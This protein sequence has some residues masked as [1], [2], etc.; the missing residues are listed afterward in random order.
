M[1]RLSQSLLI[2][3]FV[4]FSWLAMQAVH[5]SGHVMG[6]WATG[7][8][9]DKV[10]LRPLI[11]SSTEL[12]HNPHPL[13]VV[14]AGPFIGCLLPLAAFVLAKV[15]SCPGLYLFRFFA[16]FCLV[17]NG[18]YIAAGSFLG[19][20]DPGDMMRNGSPRWLLI[21]FGLVTIPAGLSMWHR[22]GIYFGLAGGHG[23]V[24]PV[25]TITSIALLVLLIA[26]ELTYGGR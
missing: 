23:K 22:Q 9:V 2:V 24:H 10:V 4:L 3:S 6:A 1:M 20:A 12:G 15:N 8:V 17:A 14:W 25:A 18:V 26:A 21:L 16:G 11:L 13:I 19:G 7:G 5:E